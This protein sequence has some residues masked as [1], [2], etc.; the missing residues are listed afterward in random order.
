MDYNTQRKKLIMPEYGRNVQKM[1]EYVKGIK[2][3]DKRNEQIKTVLTVM[4]ILNPSLRDINDFKH[5]L[6]DHV[7]IISD[8]EIDID[9]PY[10]IPTKETFSAKPDPI[11][12]ER[13]PLKA[14]HY[15]RNIQNMIDM[16]AQKE[17]GEI[18]DNMIRVLA[19]YMRQ[20][21]LIWNKDTVNEETIFADIKRLSGGKLIVGPDIHI[22]AHK[23]VSHN[24]KDGGHGFKEGSHS[25]QHS[26]QHRNRNPKFRNKNGN[27]N[28]NK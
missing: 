4:G 24:Y 9:S 28:R 7:Q 15:G 23:E 12:L 8:F 6:W 1:V 2:D 5:K 10:P 16:V 22:G 21:Y 14:A 11:P 18:K 3:K 17:D 19:N 27:K 20:Q 26:A 25:G 13:S